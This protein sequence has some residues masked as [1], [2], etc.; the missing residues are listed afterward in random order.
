M[1]SPMMKNIESFNLQKAAC[2]ELAYF[3]FPTKITEAANACND[4]LQAA[5]SNR[6]ELEALIVS[7]VAGVLGATGDLSGP[8]ATELLV[9]LAGEDNLSSAKASYG[10]IATSKA[11]LRL[12]EHHLPSSEYAPAVTGAELAFN[13]ACS[14][15]LSS[16]TGRLFKLTLERAKVG[17]DVSDRVMPWH[18]IVRS[19]VTCLDPEKAVLTVLELVRR[20]EVADF[21]D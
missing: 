11:F 19:F 16:D 5:L 3:P 15:F 9:A 8:R 1:P 4:A 6:K 18:D 21:V 17:L 14:E 13:R 12:L 2:M 10:E 20:A 7:A